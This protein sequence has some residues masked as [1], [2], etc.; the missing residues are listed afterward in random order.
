MSIAVGHDAERIPKVIVVDIDRFSF[1]WI[2]CGRSSEAAKQR[3]TLH[4]L[5]CL[6]SI[7]LFGFLR[8]TF[9]QRQIDI[10]ITILSRQTRVATYP[11]LSV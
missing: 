5:F 10:H 6:W 2:V 4:V 3:T 9:Q 7:K 11:V 1:F 8:T